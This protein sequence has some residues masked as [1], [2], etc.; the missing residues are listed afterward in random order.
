M[1][2]LLIC[3][4]AEGEWNL[5]VAGSEKAGREKTSI[6]PKH[7]HSC[8]ANRYCFKISWCLQ[9]FQRF[10]PHFRILY[11]EV[12]PKLKELWDSGH[13]VVISCLM[14]YHCIFFFTGTTRYKIKHWYSQMNLQAVSDHPKCKH[15][16]L[17]MVAGCL[18]DVWPQGSWLWVLPCSN[19]CFW[20]L[21][22]VQIHL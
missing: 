13:K 19:C 9:L 2:F 4:Q 20:G 7:L 11:S 6:S 10:I 22:N 3:R 21:I 16:W 14:I 18:Q 15:T 17:L 1:R 5:C 12:V 8:E